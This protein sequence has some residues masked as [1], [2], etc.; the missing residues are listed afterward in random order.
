LR[1][2]TAHGARKGPIIGVQHV[3][4]PSFARI[5]RKFQLQSVVLFPKVCLSHANT[6][7]FGN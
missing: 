2:F 3:I 5:S 1:S 4:C 6:L 7:T